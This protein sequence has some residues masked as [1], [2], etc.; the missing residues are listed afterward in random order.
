VEV[1]TTI[2]LGVHRRLFGQHAKC[3]TA[4]SDSE[5]WRV[6]LALRPNPNLDSFRIWLVGSRVDPGRFESDID[7]VLSP[8]AGFPLSDQIIE[9]A[10]WYCRNYG[11]YVSNP[12][13]VVDPCFR[14]AGPTVEFK[15]LR[16]H[17]ILKTIKL[18]SPKLTQ[19][20]LAGR[21]RKYRRLGYFSIEYCRRAGDTHYYAKL[22]QRS[23]EGSR[24]PYLRPAI[25]VLT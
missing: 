14:A 19:E 6:L 23:F 2:E 24:S 8:R 16:S 5:M 18:L 13:V 10:L 4:V 21:I 11:L 9:R 15:A 7:V 20:V 3:V 22:P 17:S 25:E 12:P 1:L